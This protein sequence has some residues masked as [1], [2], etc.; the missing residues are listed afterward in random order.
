MIYYC[1]LELFLYFFDECFNS[2]FICSLCFFFFL[3][4]KEEPVYKGKKWSELTENDLKL[5]SFECP[6]CGEIFS[7]TSQLYDHMRSKYKNPTKCHIC[8]R[9]M[10]AMA[11]LLSHSY[12]HTN[13]KPYKC[14]KSG[15]NFKTRTRFGLRVHIGSCCNI[16]KWK[17]QRGNKIN[18]KNEKK[19][20]KKRK[21]NILRENNANYNN[22]N[23]FEYNYNLSLITY[24]YNDLL[25]SFLSLKDTLSTSPINTN[26]N[27]NNNDNKNTNNNSD[28]NKCLIIRINLNNIYPIDYESKLNMYIHM[29]PIYTSTFE[30]RL[31]S[32]FEPF[33]L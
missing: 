22:N 14:I 21:K 10:N 25:N 6:R 31:Y 8:N 7:K 29:N 11:N 5:T 26:N 17:Y 3:M 19:N 33:S 4:E 18:I 13:K 20:K 15:C 28:N 30:Q 32:P 2:V 16:K 23:L 1:Y 12:I 9:E 24:E 27:C